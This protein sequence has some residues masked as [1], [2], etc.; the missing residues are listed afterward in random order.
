MISSNALAEA[1]KVEFP[2]A[3]PA[4]TLKQHVGLTDIEVD[5]SRPGVKNRD[6]FG[7]L[8]PYARSG[9]QA[10]TRLQK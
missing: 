9:A 7:G 10:L 3:Q 8:V 4:C 5:Y 1:P 6:I 2:V